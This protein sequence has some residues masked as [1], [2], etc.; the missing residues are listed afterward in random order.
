MPQIL[1]LIGVASV[2]WLPLA[3]LGTHPGEAAGP[4]QLEPSASGTIGLGVVGAAAEV[5]SDYFAS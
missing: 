4:G 3:A 1:D 2:V 5:S